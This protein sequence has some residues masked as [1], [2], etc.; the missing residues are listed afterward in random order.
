MLS[1]VLKMTGSSMTRKKRDLVLKAVEVST[2]IETK[3]V[4]AMG[5]VID[6]TERDFVERN[7]GLPKTT[8]RDT[9]T[10]KPSEIETE[11]ADIE[12]TMIETEV[13]TEAGMTEETA[14]TLTEE[15]TLAAGAQS[16]ASAGTPAAA[17]TTTRTT[18]TT[19]RRE[20]A[21]AAHPPIL[22]IES[23]SA[24]RSTTTMRK[25]AVARDTAT[26]MRSRTRRRTRTK[27]KT[28][29]RRRPRSTKIKTRTR[30][31]RRRRKH[32]PPRH[33]APAIRKMLPLETDP[34]V[35]TP[36]KWRLFLVANKYEH[37]KVYFEK[38]TKT[39]NC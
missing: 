33:I 15:E 16:G 1:R 10:G 23:E 20:L 25:A 4:V 29:K 8:T 5:Q 34:I 14:D 31:G 7:P 32:P 2:D 11:T 37:Q 3:I 18:A 36:N 17:T 6:P 9:G 21:P 38:I 19:A 12:M 27:T 35:A 22:A 13:E 39:K 24:G 28:A 30:T 26:G